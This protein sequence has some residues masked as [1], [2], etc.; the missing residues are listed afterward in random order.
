V[1]PE[2]DGEPEPDADEPFVAF[3]RG[4][5]DVMGGEWA[6]NRSDKDDNNY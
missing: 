2:K 6:Q 1:F 4:V 3:W 5:A